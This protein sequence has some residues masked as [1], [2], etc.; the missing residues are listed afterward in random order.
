M[1]ETDS[2][3]YKH[4]AIVPVLDTSAPNFRTVGWRVVEAVTRYQELL[5]AL[6]RLEEEWQGYPIARAPRDSPQSIE[7]GVKDWR[8]S[9][10]P[11]ARYI[12]MRASEVLH[13]ARIALDYCA[14]HVVWRDSGTAREGTKFPLVNEAG[15]WGNQKR[16]SLPRITPEHAAW[17]R[18]IQ[19]FNGVEWSS[20]L[21][22]L[23]NRDKHRMAVDI[24][25]TY[26][27]RLDTRRQ[28][29]DPEGDP[30]YVGYQVDEARLELNIAPGMDAS[31]GSN[32]GYPLE[33][34]MVGILRGVAELVNRFLVEAQYKP[35]EL[36]FEEKSKGG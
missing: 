27:C 34:T 9:H 12:T 23:S 6:P 19:P 3:G 10:F 35:I 16:S 24:L 2:E 30:D 7:L 28:F 17:I 26:R 31:G 22:D 8:W 32:A 20:R 25:P 11:A 18:E 29:A 36:A 1:L 4:L 33:V 14:Y 21:L 15:K 5:A 13:H